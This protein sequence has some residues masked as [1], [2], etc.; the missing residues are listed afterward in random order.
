[1]RVL[2]AAASLFIVGVTV[3]G[4]CCPCPSDLSSAGALEVAYARGEL[5]PIMPGTTITLAQSH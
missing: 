3:S 1:M 4:C 5:P 2:L